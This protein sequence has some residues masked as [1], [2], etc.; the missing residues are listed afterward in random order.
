[1]ADL[2]FDILET[3]NASAREPLGEKITVVHTET[4]EK[5]PKERSPCNWEVKPG[6]LPGTIS[7]RSRLGDKFEGTAKEFN[8]ILRS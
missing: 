6:T 8:E 7:A 5:I 2:T 3:V 1:M 4:V